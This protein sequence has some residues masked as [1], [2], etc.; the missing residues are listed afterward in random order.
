V[1][2]MVDKKLLEVR[3]EKKAQRPKF[4]RHAAHRKKKLGDKWRRPK[5]LQNKLRLG[6]KS[7]GSSVETGYRGPVAVRGLTDEGKKLLLVKT[8]HDV[9]SAE[10]ELHALIIA[11]KIG[12]KRRLELIDEATKQGFTIT[13][14]DVKTTK[15]R[16]TA[17]L[18][19]RTKVRDERSSKKLTQQKDLEAKAKKAEAD[20]KD[21]A[22]KE[23]AKANEESAVDA[24]EKKV[25]E[26]KE[27]DKI[28][29]KKDDN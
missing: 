11:G 23:K 8:M 15:E 22:E 21:E 4:T 19:A 27:Q 20:K 10:P 9:V 2:I 12:D 24:I 14:L 26:K 6:K 28:L 13:N 7:R 1:K 16:I 25:Q 29:T 3:K 18:S 17:T 5:G